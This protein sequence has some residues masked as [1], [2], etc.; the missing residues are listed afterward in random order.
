MR[1]TKLKLSATILLLALGLSACTPHQQYRTKTSLCVN[2]AATPSAECESHALQKYQYLSES[3]SNQ[4]QDS[5]VSQE[6]LLGFVEFDDQG[7]LFDR[8]QME[9]VLNTIYE[10]AVGK[11]LLI[12]VFMH[13]WQHNAAPGDD[14]VDTF[15]KLLAQI[16]ESEKRISLDSNEPPRQVVGVYLGWRGRTITTSIFD[17]LSFWER[18]DTARK[19]GEI[20]VSEVL[21]RLERIKQDK[22]SIGG[23]GSRTRL[24]V[25][26][27]GFGGTATYAAVT[28]ALKSRFIQT[29]AP[30]GTQGDVTGFGNLVVLIN[31]ALTA[32]QFTPLSDLAAGHATYFGSQLPVVAVLT[33]ETDYAT[34]MLLPLGRRLSTLFETERETHRWNATTKKNEPIDERDMDVTA[35]GHYLPYRTHYLHATE[36]FPSSHRPELIER[37]HRTY[38]SWVLD[39]PGSQIEFDGS[40]LERTN[41]S[42]GRNPYL[43]VQVNRDLIKNHGDISDKRIQEFVKELVMVSC[44]TPKMIEKTRSEIGSFRR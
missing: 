13:G 8:K 42:A 18:R 19:I 36:E 35:L 17:N 7:L 33:S 23:D 38:S 6:Y 41:H 43:V 5:A 44:Q 27:N 15:R 24:A 29:I 25:I 11:D 40:V 1:G 21:S 10:E 31:P 22:D 3:N 32:L 26:G 37:F 20:G 12:T 34:K 28:Q 39:Y 16:N 9:A 14:N 30:E 4:N 2:Q